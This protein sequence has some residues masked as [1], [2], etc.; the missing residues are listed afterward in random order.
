M[1]NRTCAWLDRATY[2][3]DFSLSLKIRCS[4][5][6]DVAFKDTSG[7]HFFRHNPSDLFLNEPQ[8]QK[9]FQLF[10]VPVDVRNIPALRSE[11]NLS[12]T[13]L[14]KRSTIFE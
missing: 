4:T 1:E 13:E 8:L 14:H 10:F 6:K 2:A 5:E 7:P 12:K 3:R 11:C 9:N